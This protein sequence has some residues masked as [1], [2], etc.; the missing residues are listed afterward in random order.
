MGCR[1]ISPG[2][3]TVITYFLPFGRAVVVKSNI[4]GEGVL[5]GLGRR[6]MRLML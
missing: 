6:I 2:A 3:Q 4:E 5:P 1:P